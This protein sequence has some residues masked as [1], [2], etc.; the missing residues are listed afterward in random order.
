[1][2]IG[3]VQSSYYSFEEYKKC[4]EKYS[5]YDWREINFQNRVVLSLLDRI[6]INESNIWI[7]DASTQFKNRESKLHTR[8]PYAGQY[9]PDLLIAKDWN[10][11]NKEKSKDD[12][13]AVVEV[14]S[15]KMDSLRELKNHTFNEVE[16]YKEHI[17][18]IILTDCYEWWFFEKGKKLKEFILH[19]KNGW[20]I[21]KIKNP[22]F[23]VEQFGFDEMREEPKDWDDL[24]NYIREFIIPKNS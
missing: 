19:D 6:F 4:V 18:K 13:Y 20:R 17:D 10:Y 22:E 15:P 12:Y 16:D 2:D 5:V 9:T 3:I 21:K 14:K 11:E 23:V 24:L 1:M 8:V 7:V